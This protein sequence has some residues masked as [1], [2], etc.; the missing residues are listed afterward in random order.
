MVFILLQFIHLEYKAITM[1]SFDVLYIKRNIKKWPL[2]A[3]CE[4]FDFG[5]L[6]SLVSASSSYK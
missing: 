4:N 1:G 3:N 2:E 6:T 5:H